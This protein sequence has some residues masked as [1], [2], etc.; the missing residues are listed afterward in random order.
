MFENS[1]GFDVGKKSS[2]CVKKANL[3][4]SREDHTGCM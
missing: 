3:T 4:D 1:C 2:K